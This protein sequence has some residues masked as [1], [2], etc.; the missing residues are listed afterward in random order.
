M[1]KLAAACA[2]VFVLLAGS[3][4]WTG[5]AQAAPGGACALEEWQNPSNWADCVKRTGDALGET[6][7]CAAAPTPRSPTSGLAGTFASQPDSAKR[8]GVGG[9]YSDYGVSGYGLDTY[10]LGCLGNLKHPDLVA[11]NTIAT[12][13]FTVAA[14]VL[15]AANSLRD[16]AYNPGSMWDWSDAFV[17]E[18]TTTVYEQVFSVFGVV[19]LAG[20]GLF[21]I[22]TSRHGNMS[23]AMSISGWAA[24]I[25]I[26]ASI[27][28]QWP[29]ASVH[30]ADSAASGGLRIVHNLLGPGPH[31]VPEGE[32]L[33]GGDSCKDHRTVATRASDVVTEAILYKA[34]LRAVL[35]D[36]DSATARTYGMALYNSTSMTWGEAARNEDPTLRQQLIDGKAKQWDTIAAQIQKDDSIAYEHLQGVHGVDRAGAGFVAVISALA[37]AFYDCIASVIILFGFG[38]FRIGVIAFPLLATIGMFRPA[39]A[40]VRR[41]MNMAIS[42][43]FNIV[44]FGAAAGLYLTFT[45]EILAG[46]LPG[47]AKMLLVAICGFTALA[48][49]HPIRQMYA[50]VT[51]RSRAKEGIIYRAFNARK[52]ASAEKLTDLLERLPANADGSGDGRRPETSSGRRPAAHRVFDVLVPSAAEAA[53][54]PII[55]ATVDAA[56]ERAEGITPLGRVQRAAAAAATATAAAVAGP[57]AGAAAA[58]ATEKTATRPSPRPR[59]RPRPEDAA[60][61]A[62]RS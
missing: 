11:W 50:T 24:F 12:G 8:D 29:V 39:S 60:T 28:A 21:L 1:R 36:A 18:A 6:A 47:W 45:R 43:L 37:F 9:L 59:P 30:A 44:I 4:V 52:Q 32:C 56:T 48:L 61:T 22:W 58:A 7:G 2:A 42:G 40:G 26:G 33:L 20:I 51:G 14:A 15:G 46:A 13:E 3:M 57:A 27:V 62:P 19:T 38:L 53:R 49:T 34:W 55:T 25:I 31:E 41:L 35:G 23:A 17:A 10:D 16:R 54:N 5:P